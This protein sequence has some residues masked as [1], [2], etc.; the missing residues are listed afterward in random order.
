MSEARRTRATVLFVD[1]V[2]FT[3]LSERL[4]PERAYLITT[5][6]LRRLDAIARRHG[7]GVDKYLGD[8]LMAV[9]GYPL[10]IA[11]A[12]R[13]ACRAAIEMRDEVRRYGRELALDPPL[14]VVIGVNT[15]W[16]VAGDIRGHV[17]REFHVLGDAVNVAARL[18][19][20]AP[21]GSIYI[22]PETREEIEGLAEA[23]A[24]E[25]LAL[26][27]RSRPLPAFELLAIRAGEGGGPDVPVAWSPLL[28]REQELDQL[29][30]SLRELAAGRGGVTSLVGAAGMG[31]SRL[32][33]ELVECEELAPLKVLRGHGDPPPELLDPD[34]LRQD[35][36]SAPLLVVLDDLDGA[37]LDSLRALERAIAE[38][39]REPIA[40]LLAHRPDLEARAP[41]LFAAL[42]EGGAGRHRTIALGPLD[43]AQSRQLVESLVGTG[44]I[45]EETWERIHRRAGGV[46]AH[47]I[48]AGFLSPALRDES[49]GAPR[50]SDTERRRATI[51]FADIT[52]FTAM[53]E[54]L[55]PE[56]AY[57]IVAGCLRLLDEVACRHG[58]TVEKYLG[59][60]VMALFG[61]PRAIEDAPRAALNAAIEMRRR[62]RE[63]YR[64]AGLD[65]HI[66]VH[67][68]LG[69]AGDVSGPLIREFAVMGDPVN[70][71][72]RLKDLAPSGSIYVG[73]G[74]QRSTR[75]SFEFR[76]LEPLRIPG[77]EAQVP[78]HELLSREERLHRPRIGVGRQVFS[79]LVGREE[80]LERLRGSVRE[81]S[82]GRS[83]VL[84]VV[85]EAGLGKSRLIAEAAASAEARGVV[86]LEGRS[87]STGQHLSFHPFADLGRSWAGITDLDDE[88][89][90]RGKLEAGV[91]QLMGDR[92]ES[93]FP[94]IATVMGVRLE[95]PL[96]ERIERMQGDALERLI[97]RSVIEL[98]RRQSELRPLAI[99]L[100]D[101]HWADQTSIE[102]LESLLPLVE[103]RS[104]LFVLAA[105]PGFASTSGRVLA[106]A[107]EQHADR[108]SEIR[109]HPLDARA[110]RSL[111]NNLFRHEDLPYETRRLIESKAGGN[112]FYIE[113]VVRSLV[114]QGAVE[115]D[116]DGRFRATDRIGDVEIP[117]T[118]QEVIMSRV[119][120]LELDE[121]RLLQVASV[122]GGS[123]HEEVLAGVIGDGGI[124]ELVRD[125]IDAEF[126]V[127][128]D[129]SQGV[130]YAFK[131]PLI[132][133]VTYDGL[134]EARREEL[135]R[136]VAAAMETR[137]PEDLPGFEG[138]IAY[139]FS[140]GRDAARA[141]TYL[142]R[143][144]DEAAR[145]AGSSEALHFFREAS[146][147]YL[148]LHGEG[149]DPAKKA[150]LQRSIARALYFRGQLVEA[151][152]SYNRAI[153]LLGESVPRRHP[154]LGLRFA[155][156]LAGALLRV[157]LPNAE[158][159]PAAT[160][161]DREVIDLMFQR[162]LCEVTADATRFLFDSI[163]LLSKLSSFDPLS[164]PGAGGLYGGSAV[165]FSYGGV[166]FA[167]GRRILEQAAR[168]VREDDIAD[169]IP[170]RM[171][172]FT[173]HFLEGDWSE[174]HEIPE[175]L[176]EQGLRGGR[177]WDVL[178][179]LQGQTE[180]RICMGDFAAAR[181]CMALNDR[182]WDDYQNDLARSQH[183]YF[184]TALCL[185]QRR[186]EDAVRAADE[187]YE[188]NPEPSLHIHALSFKARA[189]A[190]LGDLE[191]AEA[192]LGVCADLIAS[193]GQ[194]TVPKY[195]MSQYLRARLLVDLKRLAAA[196]A[197]GAAPARR[198]WRRRAL[199]TAR[200]A[201][202]ASAWVAE[203]RPEVYRLA[204]EL[205]WLERAPRRALHWW[206]RGL[207]VARALGARP[208]LARTLAELGRH[209]PAGAAVVVGDE[210]LDA[211]GCRERAVALFAELDLEWDLERVSGTP[212]G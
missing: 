99:V 170:Y 23:R 59:D 77:R 8:C 52:G 123:F 14:D 81:L 173:H 91:T 17:V 43:Q 70:V 180:K 187:Y 131:H 206:R 124:A 2:G 101:L 122:I 118:V 90:V 46:P 28:G 20:R 47:V 51:L 143:A 171:M 141:E 45:P 136:A 168:V 57:P 76:P 107:R 135:H 71:A 32:L 113:E 117:G 132:Q 39:A 155:R 146:R 110:C 10:P 134:L 158:R 188:E 85:A 22:G 35:A 108:L 89:S 75:D 208:E 196:R 198:H 191:R 112:P 150:R 15:G 29:R 120:R 88:A 68:G 193:Q 109:L 163:A 60:C 24:L 156:N 3:T 202:R 19:A 31:K 69:I 210:R 137:L 6:C 169:V 55:G 66:G 94:F 140:K 83:A 100:E 197:D 102:L 154:A 201:V 182:I 95:G 50:S 42:R 40:F 41:A 152:E 65:V 149:G 87:L 184:A 115:R 211:V 111:V 4:G 63:E 96:R 186:L 205:H 13:S 114:D 194:L 79:P 104:I 199:A 103:E 160:E 49:D 121:R 37:S 164:V 207:A 179:Y 189:L 165:I 129:R 204:G 153:E 209:L 67:T 148:D 106:R 130:E 1:L 192:A 33:A 62:V 181:H 92:A 125:L 16:M 21:L 56:Q 82:A 38:F 147:L 151:V 54:R 9:F 27:G 61:I 34:C 12:A 53:T 25:P 48:A 86:W 133:E 97:R 144:G 139:H 127:P 176:L 74:V 105:R 84:A 26:K 157:H 64:D 195:M 162:G 190:L 7:A 175:P 200:R 126:L 161:R 178:S 203:R 174:E 138:M 142:F 183:G 159:R 166:S 11:Q 78:A 80:E 58:G 93:I 212:R 116:A 128:W 185:E 73:D 98:L 119:D 167:I 172:R 44:V 177:T 145:A 18:K 5:G 36:G 30:A 72:D